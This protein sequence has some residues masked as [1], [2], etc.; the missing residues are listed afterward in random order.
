[1]DGDG[2]S[3]SRAIPL[4]HTPGGYKF[5][6]TGKGRRGRSPYAVKVRQWW[7]RPAVLVGHPCERT[8]HD[9]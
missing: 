1:M 3:R 8:H 9:Q 7:I 6:L 2:R 5:E 4:T